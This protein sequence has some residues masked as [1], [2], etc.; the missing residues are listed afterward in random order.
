VKNIRDGWYINN[1]GER[2][3]QKIQTETGVLKGIKTILM[4][5]RKFSTL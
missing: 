5:R 3:I 4:E 1:V 2:V